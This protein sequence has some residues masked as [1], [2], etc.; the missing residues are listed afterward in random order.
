MMEWITALR[1]PHIGSINYNRSASNA[2]AEL[3]KSG[4]VY[5]REVKSSKNPHCTKDP[6]SITGNWR[7]IVLIIRSNGTLYQFDENDKTVIENIKVKEVQRNHISMIDESALKKKN[8]FMLK[9][10]QK[11]HFFMTD[12]PNER[13]EWISILKT[14][15]Q[16]EVLGYSE[17]PYFCYRLDR[18]FW[19]SVVEGRGLSQ[20]DPYCYIELDAERKGRTSTKPKTTN[21]V[22][23]EDFLFTD[24][25]ALRRGVEVIVM[26]KN[27]LHKDSTIG[28]VHLPISFIRRGETHEGWYPIM[29]ES[30]VSGYPSETAGELHLR[31]KYDEV[32]V[33][34]S[35]SYDSLLKLLLDV[36]SRLIFD[37]VNV[38]KN[39]EW[40]A[41][42]MMRIYAA[43]NMAMEWLLFLARNEVESTDDANILFRGNSI[44]TKAID[45]YMKLIGLQYVDE[46]IGEIVRSICDNKVYVEVDELKLERYEDIRAHWKVLI[47]YTKMLWKSIEKTQAK[48]PS[49]LRVFFSELRAIIQAKYSEQNQSV[50]YTCVS[51]FIFLRLFCPALLNPKQFQLVKEQPDARTRRTLTL[52][53]KTTQSLANLSD[54]N[55]KEPYMAQMNEFVRQNS[56]TL[57]EYIDYIATGQTHN[58]SYH[59]IQALQPPETFFKPPEVPYLID[60]DKKLS[61]FCSYVV[62]NR[63]HL[64]DLIAEGKTACSPKLLRRLLFHCNVAEEKTRLITEG[65]N[66]RLASS[67]SSLSDS[68]SQQ[69]LS[70]HRSQSSFQ[71]SSFV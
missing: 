33:L 35:S 34:P 61:S 52:L 5:I 54:C 49:E 48:C 56:A 69:T 18:T 68:S 11:T 14:F 1:I 20:S 51:G 45:G 39:L 46:A 19:I 24:L 44:F 41:E 16:P 37:L 62:H 27:R 32:V 28:K 36:E 17:P 21:P 23:V 6:L 12:G 53:A 10:K 50:R 29:Y 3:I 4:T 8:C 55:P 30:K 38:S 71:S 58:P 59:K 9:S 42:N 25:P 7:R 60:I 40:F 66:G 57:M 64:E 2:G 26:N 31:F 22:W 70:S 47:G 67:I 15:A 63:E 13:N 65:R 43:K